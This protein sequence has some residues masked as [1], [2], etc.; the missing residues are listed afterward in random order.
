M[1]IIETLKG[2]YL[3]G[4]VVNWSKIQESMGS[5][6]TDLFERK[7]IAKAIVDLLYVEERELSERVLRDS[8]HHFMDAESP[9]CFC[10]WQ[11]DVSCLAAILGFEELR[12]EAVR[13]QCPRAPLGYREKPYENKSDTPLF[14]KYGHLSEARLNWVKEAL[15]A[16]AEARY[17][18]FRNKN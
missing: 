3:D 11:N 14:S 15:E 1:K 5:L 13:F 7:L 17:G 10:G 9:N 4:N 12:I 2:Q 18:Q 16:L 8:L 6:F